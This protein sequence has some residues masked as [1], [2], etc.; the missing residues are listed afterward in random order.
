V[1]GREES[2]RE[3]GEWREGEWNRKG[4]ERNYKLSLL[5]KR[6]KSICRADLV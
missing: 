4:D 2:G 5:P 3:V 1:I 6:S